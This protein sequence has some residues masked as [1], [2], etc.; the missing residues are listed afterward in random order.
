MSA[1]IPSAS[2]AIATAALALQLGGC[3]AADTAKRAASYTVTDSAGVSIVTS[4]AA[5]WGSDPITLDSAPLL[6][7]GQESAGP[8]QFSFVMHGLLLADGR[9][10]VAELATN[11]VRVYSAAGEHERSFGRRGNGPGESH[12]ISA[13]AMYGGDSL[14]THDQRLRRLTVRS[15]TSGESRQVATPSAGNWSAFGLT[16]DGGLLLYD[17]GRS[18]RPGATPGVQWDSTEIVRVDVANGVDT[19]IARLPSRQQHIL[20]DGNTTPFGP[21][22]L[23]VY[24]VA[25]DGFYWATTDRYG[26]EFRT[27][28]GQLQRVLRRPVQPAPVTATLT[29]QWIE[30]SLEE[31]VRY[32]GEAT[33]AA[34][35]RAL[36]AGPFGTH[37]PLFQQA[38]VDQE[39]RLWLGAGV[40][41][42]LSAPSPSW[43]VFDAQGAWLGDVTM[44]PRFRPLDARGDRVLG[45]ATDDDDVPFLEVRRLRLGTRQSSR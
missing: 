30:R 26:V 31:F 19:V 16:A 43:S 44:P 45:V 2:L 3:R 32:N 41:P 29:Q 25:P 18:Y 11:E 4:R 14:V 28:H 33:A 8:Y 34:Q 20:P 38:L 15:L 21:A 7:I 39:Q 1:R 6:R 42:E 37:V 17:P 13:L 27:A 5:A 40:W 22:H 12:V 24:A 36:E 10:A 9:I 23:A 35:R